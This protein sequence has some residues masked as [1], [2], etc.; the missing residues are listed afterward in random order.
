M[1]VGDLDEL[2]ERLHGLLELLGKFRLLLILPSV[3]QRGEAGLQ[4]RRALGDIG[5]EAAQLLG[6]APHL[7]GVNDGLRHDAWMMGGTLRV[8]R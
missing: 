7:R 4:L 6:E 5:V 8:G 3:A 1:L 2:L